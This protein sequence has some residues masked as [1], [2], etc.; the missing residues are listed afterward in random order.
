[1]LSA[2]PGFEEVSPRVG[3]LDERALS[4]LERRD[5][6]AALTLL[7]E[8]SGATDERLRRLAR[9]LS[10]RVMVRAASPRGAPRPGAG[11]IRSR[12]WEP[13][14][15]VD[16]DASLDELVASN[17]AG[18]AADPAGLRGPGWVRP[19]TAIS[20]VLD[21]SGSMGGA[22]LATAAVAAAAVALRGID[23]YSVI[24][25]GSAV[26]VVKAQRQPRAVESVVDDLLSLRG[27]GRTDLAAA[28]RAAARR[29]VGLGRIP[30]DRSAALGRARHDRGGPASGSARTGRA[31]RARAGRPGRV[32]C[33]G[34]RTGAGGRR[35]G[36]G[37]DRTERCPC[38]DLRVSGRDVSA[39]TTAWRA[40]RPVRR[41]RGRSVE[42]LQDEGRD[43]T[44]RRVDATRS[45]AAAATAPTTR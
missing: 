21:R 44:G 6:D 33:A 11:R 38:R 30:A 27:H 18:R 17:L 23:D 25:F 42:S 39:V 16:V 40:V 1:M 43:L 7:A 41:C 4:E 35:S 15:D 12:R 45:I 28:L 2:I 13:G 14:V 10:G 22:R 8:M 5:P 19:A 36:G 31:A 37:G 34:A 29:T 24:A 20:L 9:A 26:R 3:M 32:R